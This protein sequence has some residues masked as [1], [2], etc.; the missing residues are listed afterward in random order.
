MHPILQSI[1]M[2]FWDIIRAPFL[3]AS[4][5]WLLGP[6]FLLWFTLEFYFGE[7]KKESL[8]WNTSLANGISL[9]WIGLQ[10]MNHLFAYKGDGFWGKFAAII[11][12]ISY[13]L[14]IA[15]ISFAHKFTPKIVY[16]LASPTPIYFMSIVVVLWAFDQ[17]QLKGW[18]ILDLFIFFGLNALF[19]YIIRKLLPSKEEDKAETTEETTPSL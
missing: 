10:A 17:L 8:G 5:W 3:K 14:F 12:V 11:V 13:G 19:F 7:Y 1:L 2:G 16:T 9:T 4:T 6:I 18:I 15:Y